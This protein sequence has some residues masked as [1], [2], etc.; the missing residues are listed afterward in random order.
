[1]GVVLTT[2]AFADTT[3][4]AHRIATL[5]ADESVACWV[6]A[7]VLGFLIAILP[8]GAP[9]LRAAL[10]RTTE[11]LRISRPVH[12]RVLR[13]RAGI[14]I[15]LCSRVVVLGLVGGLLV[16]IG[17]LRPLDSMWL[18]PD[19]WIAGAI[20]VVAQLAALRYA[21]RASGDWGCGYV[22]ATSEVAQTLQASRRP[23]QCPAACEELRA[24]T[25]ALGQPTCNEPQL[26]R[27][28]GQRVSRERTQN[29]PFLPAF[30]LL[31]RCP[32]ILRKLPAG[33][34]HR[35]ARRL[36]ARPPQGRPR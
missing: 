11:F 15:C 19:V 10:Y 30:W 1:V 36:T 33:A 12:I 7:F 6:V 28:L 3:P 32:R 13:S 4:T 20:H 8:P 17:A 24:G 9:G 31:P 34:A 23:S 22:S 29:V 27:T 21:W 26:R 2:R 14:G 5:S 18:V 16:R 35:A 25:Y